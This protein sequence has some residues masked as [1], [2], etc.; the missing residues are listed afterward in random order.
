MPISLISIISIAI[1]L[2]FLSQNQVELKVNS[3]EL[4]VKFPV[5]KEQTKTRVGQSWWAEE[6]ENHGAM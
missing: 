5:V 3:V 1:Q 4:K 6:I 2:N